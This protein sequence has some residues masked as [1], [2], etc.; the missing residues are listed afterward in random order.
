MIRFLSYVYWVASLD[1]GP[2][3]L[4]KQEKIA[5]SFLQPV[6]NESHVIILSL[7]M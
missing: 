2:V 4:I 5:Q 7:P 6:S 1:K 3:K